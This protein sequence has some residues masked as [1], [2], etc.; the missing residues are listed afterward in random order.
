MK[1]NPRT[2]PWITIFG[3]PGIFIG[4]LIG[5]SGY[6][7]PM[8]PAFWGM[9]IGLA[10]GMAVRFATTFSQVKKPSDTNH[11]DDD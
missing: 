8:V 1:F 4:Y 3:V 6:P 5:K 2:M 11:K 7:D 9:C 10:L